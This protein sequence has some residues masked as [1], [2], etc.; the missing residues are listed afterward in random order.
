[1][2]LSEPH[3]SKSP[4]HFSCSRPCT[5]NYRKKWKTHQHFYILFVSCSWPCHGKINGVDY[6]TSIFVS[7]SQPCHDEI[8]DMHTVSFPRGPTLQIFVDVIPNLCLDSKILGLIPVIPVHQI[9]KFVL[10]LT[11]YGEITK[12]YKNIDE[13][14]DSDSRIFPAFDVI[15]NQCRTPRSFLIL[16]RLQWHVLMMNGINGGECWTVSFMDCRPTQGFSMREAGSSIWQQG[17]VS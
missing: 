7:C 4:T 12:F 10:W 5:N 11:I 3:T 9:W 17:T 16:A 13:S 8:D 2:S 1:M 6:S 14:S 15:R